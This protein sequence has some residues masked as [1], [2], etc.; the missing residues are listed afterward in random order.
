MEPTDPRLAALYDL[1]NPDGPD[2][3]GYRAL[4]DRI[5]ADTIVDLGCGT[6]ILTVTLATAGR[7]VIGIDPDAG[8]LDVA[9]RRPGAEVVRWVRGDSAQ[10]A[11][12]L[13][14]A[15]RG[16]ADLALMT[17]N[18]AMHIGPADWPTTLAHLAAGL[19]I[20]GTLS[21][22]T[23]NPAAEAWRTWTPELTRG[24]RDTEFGELTEWLEMEGPDADGTVVLSAHNLWTVTGEDLVVD[25]TL[26][27]R[28][29]DDLETSLGAAGLTVSGAA[30]GWSGQPIEPT[31]PLIV[32]TA[33][34][35]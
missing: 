15:G 21:F 7:T 2:H 27:F 14:T 18:V 9:R 12:A 23:R 13:D 26:T 17:G 30:G 34:K 33:T 35:D 1:D 22:E 32:V 8:M 10:V 3:D 11:A 20:G 24:S 19:R 25:V 29:L 5:G 28:S 4:A 16:L 31:S 6:G